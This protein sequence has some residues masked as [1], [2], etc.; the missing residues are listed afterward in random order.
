[1][2]HPEDDVDV[3]EQSDYDSDTGVFGIGQ[4]AHQNRQAR[5]V[6]R[7]LVAAIPVLHE[8]DYSGNADICLDYIFAGGNPRKTAARGLRTRD[9]TTSTPTTTRPRFG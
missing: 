6:P 9:P 8:L 1:M 2:R 5:R 4:V 7:R 3:R